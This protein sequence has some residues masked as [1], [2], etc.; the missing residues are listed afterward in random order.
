MVDHSLAHILICVSFQFN[1]AVGPTFL[2]HGKKNYLASNPVKTESLVCWYTPICIELKWRITQDCGSG[3][4]IPLSYIEFHVLGENSLGR[5][6]IVFC[7]ITFT[8]ITSKNGVSSIQHCVIKKIKSVSLIHFFTSIVLLCCFK[9]FH[10]NLCNIAGIWIAAY[11][12]SEILEET[13]RVEVVSR[14]L[15]LVTVCIVLSYWYS[16]WLM[17]Q[18]SFRVHCHFTTFTSKHLS[19]LHMIQMKGLWLRWK[20][21][22]KL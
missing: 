18:C 13:P 17:Y 14:F 10:S 16:S 4:K 8:R 9:P 2:T 19:A 1:L 21:E 22:R 7:W 5:N 11:I 15:L 6:S 20:D 3:T 12:L